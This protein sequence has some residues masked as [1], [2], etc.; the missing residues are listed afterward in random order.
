[1]LSVDGGIIMA[2]NQVWENVLPSI[3]VNCEFDSIV[4]DTSELQREKLDW[5]IT[6]T[7]DGM[8]MPVNPLTENV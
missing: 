4:T 6:S 3:R 5:S 1:M 8:I 2:V 7:D